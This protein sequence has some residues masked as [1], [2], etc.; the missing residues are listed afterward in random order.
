MRTYTN[1]RHHWRWFLKFSI[2]FFILLGK[3]LGNTESKIEF[4][5]LFWGLLKVVCASIKPWLAEIFGTRY[6]FLLFLEVKVVFPDKIYAQIDLLHY[7]YLNTLWYKWDQI[8]TEWFHFPLC[9]ALT[10]IRIYLFEWSV[11]SHIA[12]FNFQGFHCFF[13]GCFIGAARKV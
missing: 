2:P 13:F 5:G 12:F 1:T 8:H 10:D 7:S 6:A 11:F 9:M 3:I 4:W